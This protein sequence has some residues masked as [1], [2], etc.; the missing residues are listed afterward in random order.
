MDIGKEMVKSCGGLPLAVVVLGGILA[1][2]HSSTDWDAVHKN[3]KS[4]LAKGKRIDEENQGEVQR[5]L[6]L[7]YTDLPY[8]L[9]PC[10]LYLSMFS[11]DECID[12]NKLYNL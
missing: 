8:K 12:V 11:E 5:I 3:I 10:F 9:K 7:S 2:K 4:H 1:T 6:A